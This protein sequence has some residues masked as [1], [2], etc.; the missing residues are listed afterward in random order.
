[1]NSSNS[2]SIDLSNLNSKSHFEDVL[3]MNQSGATITDYE[4]S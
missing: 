2:N 1:M 4:K 3:Y